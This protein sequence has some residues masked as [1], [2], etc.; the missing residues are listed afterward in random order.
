MYKNTSNAMH[1][2]M[3]AVL[4]PYF[5]GSTHQV[6]LRIRVAFLCACNH[7]SIHP[8]YMRWSALTTLM[9]HLRLLPPSSTVDLI[10]KIVTSARNYDVSCF[11]KV[12]R[13]IHTLICN[14][15]PRAPDLYRREFR[16][17]TRQC[18]TRTPVIGLKCCC[19]VLSPSSSIAK[20]LQYTQLCL[21]VP[22]NNTMTLRVVWS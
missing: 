22:L 14:L 10:I 17:L 15:V 6:T 3:V 4:G 11:A 7:V 19:I 13:L 1:R 5:D 18:F 8:L 20:A 12:V 21:M 2:D 9:A 16:T